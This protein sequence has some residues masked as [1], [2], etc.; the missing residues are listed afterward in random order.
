MNGYEYN[1]GYY[2]VDSIYSRW[3]VFVKIISLAQNLK[4]QMF[5]TC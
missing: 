5:A 1:Q 4:Q 3:L 2:L